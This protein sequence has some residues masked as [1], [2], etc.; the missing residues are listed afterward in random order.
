MLTQTDIDI[1]SFI[2]NQIQKSFPDHNIIDEE[3][4]GIDK[5][6][7]FTWVIDPIDG[8]S[9]FAAGVPTFG[10]IIG[11]LYKGKAIAGGMSLPVFNEFCLAEKGKAAFCNG[12]KIT[13]STAKDLL[14]TLVAYN[15]DSHPQNPEFTRKECSLLEVLVNNIRNLRDSSSVFDS[16]MVA[17][18]RYGGYLSQNCKIWDNVGVQIIIEEAGGKFTG[19][20]GEEMDYS[21]PFQKLKKIYTFC[22]APPVLHEQLQKIIHQ[23][24]G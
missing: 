6:S 22:V 23:V 7:D 10:T 14:S 3:A 17:K 8:T 19:F 4:G 20:F 9:N 18:G 11:L 16:M 5:K 21:D 2:I 13:V 24:Y 15:I 12:E 1:G